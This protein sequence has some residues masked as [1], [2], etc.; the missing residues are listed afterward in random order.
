VA[1]GWVL[2]VVDL[3][4]LGLPTPASAPSTREKNPF[5]V[6]DRPRLG[7]WLTPMLGVQVRY[8]EVTRD[9]ILR[10]PTFLKLTVA[11]TSGLRM[12]D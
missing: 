8:Y 3:T 7:T 6:P 4:V 9:G 2:L 5:A 10:H 12:C 11:A 1:L